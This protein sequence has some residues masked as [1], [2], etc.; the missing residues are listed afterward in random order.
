M[1]DPWRNTGSP[2][3]PEGVADLFK[4]DW[5]KVFFEVGE[6]RPRE[7]IAFVNTFQMTHNNHKELNTTGTG[8]VG[9][10]RPGQ[11]FPK[12]E[13]QVGGSIEVTSTA[14]GSM[15][16]APFETFDDDMSGIMDEIPEEQARDL[17][18]A[19][20]IS[21]V[22][23]LDHAFDTAYVGFAPGESL[24]G[25]HLENGVTTRNRP[26]DDIGFSLLFLMR[27]NY[28]FSTL[29]NPRGRQMFL[30]GTTVFIHAANRYVAREILGSS[31]K[32]YTADNELNAL[33]QDELSWMVLTFLASSTAC[34]VMANKERNGVKMGWKNSPM[35][36]MFDNKA[37]MSA[38]STCYDRHTDSF[39]TT[40]RHWYGSPGTG[41]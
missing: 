36:D 15:V 4:I 7:Y 6:E 38:A 17:R 34:F 37:T 29:K 18:N 25:D 24:C 12:S 2:I 41:S 19:E 13:F 35:Y 9:I 40:W 10:K 3:M 31:N 1:S 20:E 30:N 32:P 8:G 22:A 33:V 11:T 27:A 21:G 28:Y 5:D 26:S 39:F 23:V 16:E 14:R